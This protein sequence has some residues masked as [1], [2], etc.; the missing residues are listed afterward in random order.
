ML[1]DIKIKLNPYLG[2]SKNLMDFFVI[3]GFEEKILNELGSR[4]IEEQDENLELTILSSAI[5]DLA[6]KIFSPDNIIKQI[7][8]DKPKIMIADP[9]NVPKPSDVVFSSCFDSTDGKK[10]VFYSCYALK[11]YE[12]YKDNKIEYYVP[13]AFLILSQYPYFATFYKICK[14]IYE[15]KD[16]KNKNTIPIEILIHCC[17]NYIPSPIEETIFLRDYNVKITKLTGY[18]QADFDICKIFNHVPINEFIKIFLIIFVE[19]DL[20]IFSPDLVKL[21]IFMFIL[22]ILNYPLIDSNYYWHIKS[23]SKDE[24]KN[25]NDTLTTSYVGVNTEFIP[26]L[27]FSNFRN[28]NFIVDLDNKKQIYI[29]NIKTNKESEEISKLLKYVNNILKSKKVK[30]KSSFLTEYITALRNKLKRITKEYNS[31]QTNVKDNFFYINDKIIEIN[32][33]IQET[34]YDFILNIL[35]VLNKDF[36]LDP[37]LK[38]PI[39][40]KNNPIQKY[41]EEENIFLDLCR[42]TIKY[43]TY[44][45]LFIKRFEAHEEIKPSLL[46]S[47]EFVTLKTKDIKK[48]IPDHIKYFDIMDQVYFMETKPEIREINYNNLSEEFKKL[49]EKSLIT[50]FKKDKKGQLFTFDQNIIKLFIFHKKSKESYKELTEKKEQEVKTIDK[51]SIP[52]I[53]LKNFTQ[54]LNRE[55]YLKSSLAYVFSISFPLFSL[56]K[57]LYFLSEVLTGLKEIQYFQ[58][59]YLCIIL[60]SID[61]YFSLNLEREQLPHLILKNIRNYIILINA[62]LINNQIIPNEELFIFFKKFCEEGINENKANNE[63]EKKNYFI[64]NIDN[65]QNYE[66]TINK[67]MIQK[68]ENKLIFKFK[69]INTACNHLDNEGKIFL[70][71]HKFFVEFNFNL[72]MLKIKEFIEIVINIIYYLDEK[73]IEMKCFLT[74][75]IFILK[76]LETELNVFYKK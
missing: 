26:N 25:G 11:F 27:D 59:Y 63:K 5:S 60:K 50:K 65:E 19:L 7:Y 42:N 22:Y 34:F 31:S 14:S 44:F 33:L 55:F 9:E 20:L 39:K 67:D 49:N 53:I 43:N 29:H 72:E 37:S 51:I 21:N 8:P 52:L 35:V 18:P 4:I 10:K 69:E 68:K 54:I 3:I 58:R 56:Q 30:F 41:S 16:N 32:K 74:N 47:D 75:L 71:I 62:H 66:K 70:N 1:E 64:F 15:I 12:K 28:H 57:G 73:N 48:D 2:C 46:F 6:Y 24:I 40:P 45:D 23:I 38:M 76:K 36:E 61:N 13:K 17:V